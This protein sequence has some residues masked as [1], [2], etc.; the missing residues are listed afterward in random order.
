MMSRDR[1]A[2][3]GFFN[4]ASLSSTFIDLTQWCRVALKSLSSRNLK[5]DISFPLYILAA[6]AKAAAL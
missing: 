1:L 5:P 6:V 2:D 3:E 4:S